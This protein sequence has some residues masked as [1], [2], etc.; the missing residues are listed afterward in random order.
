M[1]TANTKTRVSKEKKKKIK[2]NPFKFTKMLCLTLVLLAAMSLFFKSTASGFT[3]AE[4][5]EVVVRHG[6]TLWEISKDYCVNENIQK[7]VYEIRKINN[8][9]HSDIYPGQKI[10]I[11]LNF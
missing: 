9:K 5:Q 6:D 2:F 8:M 11:P 1:N 10:K 3:G 4:Y 7:V